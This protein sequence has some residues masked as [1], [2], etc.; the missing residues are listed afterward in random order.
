VIP[1]LVTAA[2]GA[3]FIWACVRYTRFMRRLVLYACA[4]TAGL[5]LWLALG[6]ANL[7]VAWAPFILAPVG[8]FLLWR[9]QIMSGARR[10]FEKAMRAEAD[11]ANRKSVPKI[12]SVET[13]EDD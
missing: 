5:F 10:R 9:G 3:G 4:A 8:A 13:I 12:L 11:E 7:Y 2:L 6:R 1:F